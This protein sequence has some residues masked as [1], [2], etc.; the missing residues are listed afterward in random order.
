M[1]SA[2]LAG[3]LE[4]LG[5]R[6]L[7]LRD[8]GLNEYITGKLS[9]DS[10]Y[11]ETQ[12]IAW[13]ER[14]ARPVQFG[15]VGVVDRDT[16]AARVL[17][18]PETVRDRITYLQTHRFTSLAEL[19]HTCRDVFA[20]AVVYKEEETAWIWDGH[21]CRHLDFFHPD[22]AKF[23]SQCQ[24]HFPGAQIVHLHRDL[25]P[26]V[27][28]MASQ[29]MHQRGWRKR[30]RFEFTHI[31]RKYRRYEKFCAQVA[32]VHLR[33]EEMFDLSVP[34]LA[35]QMARN[36]N[37]PFPDLD[38]TS[39]EYDLY[40][41]ITPHDTAFTLA[42]AKHRFLG[43]KAIARLLPL[44]KPEGGSLPKILWAEF[45]AQTIYWQALLA[46]RQRKASVS[47]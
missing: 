37:L 12:T 6:N 24:Q 23:W 47:P 40:G 15:G 16:R 30:L 42:D 38:W 28:S 45:H 8:I 39:L 9:L 35:E 46:Y 27:E 5:V 26:W 25:G 11:M 21:L 22:P 14:F 3:L 31:L 41:A 43:S 44:E 20:E 36:L 17:T 29:S 19:Y 2:L 33:F 1:G 10:K 32:G 34:A 13:I 4:K 7:P 18:D